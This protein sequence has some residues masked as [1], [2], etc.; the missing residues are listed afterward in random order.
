MLDRIAKDLNVD[1][2]DIVDFELSV[3]D[4]QP[5]CFL[6]LH[7]EFVSS[8]RL[9]NMGSTLTSIDSII[10]AS[11]KENDNADVSMIMLFDHE[12]IGS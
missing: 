3:I 8:G 11:K 1:G 10:E 12:E 5:A 7:R 6:G 4:S 2:K 9:D